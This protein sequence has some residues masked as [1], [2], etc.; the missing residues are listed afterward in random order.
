LKVVVKDEEA[1]VDVAHNTK[2]MT[3]KGAHHLKYSVLGKSPAL[4]WIRSSPL[5]LS[6]PMILTGHR[7]SL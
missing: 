2:L 1:S 7:T 6:F 3:I 5:V 4:Q